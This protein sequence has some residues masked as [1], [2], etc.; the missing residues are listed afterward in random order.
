MSGNTPL[1]SGTPE[2]GAQGGARP[3]CPFLRGAGGGGAKV[4]F[5]KIYLFKIEQALAEV[6]MCEG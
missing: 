4:P 2:R 1:S 6:I 5:Y 3:P